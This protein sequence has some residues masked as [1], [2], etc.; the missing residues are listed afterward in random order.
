[1]NHGPLRSGTTRH[2][3]AK[4]TAAVK[5]TAAPSWGSD[6]ARPAGAFRSLLAAV[7]M[8]PTSPIAFV[9]PPP[10]RAHL[11]LD[12]LAGLRVPKA[13]P[14]PGAAPVANTRKVHER[15]LHQRQGLDQKG[16]SESLANY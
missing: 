8:E 13:V 2:V 7:Y 10:P 16:E 1:M 15:H 3:G 12:K 14:I 11:K 9:S 6:M 5:G 4:T